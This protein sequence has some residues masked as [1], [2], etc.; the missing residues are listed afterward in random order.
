[1]LYGNKGLRQKSRGT[2]LLKL[3]KGPLLLEELFE[4]R[5]E[6]LKK[7]TKPR[8]GRKAFQEEKNIALR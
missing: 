8:A 1:M 2:I 6:V 3:S 5:L 4:Q 7:E